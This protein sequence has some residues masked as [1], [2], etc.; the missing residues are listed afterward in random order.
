MLLMPRI[1]VCA[2]GHI[3][4][5]DFVGKCSSKVSKFSSFNPIISKTTKIKTHHM[6]KHREFIFRIFM[7]NI[8]RIVQLTNITHDQG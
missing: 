5:Q 6:L 3:N 4:M 7:C 2:R 8:F 1:Y